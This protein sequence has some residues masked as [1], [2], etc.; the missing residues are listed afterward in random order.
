M[1]SFEENHLVKYDAILIDDDRDLVHS[2]WE[3]LAES[4]NKIIRLYESVE[5]FMLESSTI[6]LTTSIII[7]AK[8]SE[9]NDETGYAEVIYKMGFIDVTLAQCSRG[10]PLLCS[11]NIK[12]VYDK[13]PP[14]IIV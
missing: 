11:D 4:S 13:T 6:A 14:W 9:R 2:L 12:L 7:D 1:T 5:D 10:A 3:M 8:L